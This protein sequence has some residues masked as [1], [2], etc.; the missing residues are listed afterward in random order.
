MPNV[1]FD[2]TKAEM[3]IEEEFQ[4]IKKEVWQETTIQKPKPPMERKDSL[5]DRIHF[6][7]GELKL[8]LLPKKPD[9]VDSNDDVKTYEVTLFQ[10][11]YSK[12]TTIIK[13]EVR[14]EV[15][16]RKLGFGFI[17]EDE[18]RYDYK[19][20]YFTRSVFFDKMK[21]LKVQ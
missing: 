18:I 1:H 8:E 5:W 13:T 21:V 9:E 12:I 7:R 16:N 14:S 6:T 11:F 2:E 20:M 3:K 17:S 4:D 19:I 15:I 10:Y